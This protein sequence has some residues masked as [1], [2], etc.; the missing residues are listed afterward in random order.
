MID[1]VLNVFHLEISCFDIGISLGLTQNERVRL[2]FESSTLFVVWLIYIMK[3]C[4]TKAYNTVLCVFRQWK[5]NKNILESD[6]RAS[7]SWSRWG[8]EKSTFQMTKQAE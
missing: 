8:S 5:N 4:P 7:D 2:V 6:A 1:E 3:N